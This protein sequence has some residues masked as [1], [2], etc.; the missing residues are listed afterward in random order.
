LLFTLAEV[1]GASAQLTG[2]LD[3]V[4]SNDH[5]TLAALDH[6]Q[7]LPHTWCCAPAISGVQ[8]RSGMRAAIALA[9]RAVNLHPEAAGLHLLLARLLLG[10]FRTTTL[11]AP[12]NATSTAVEH[13]LTARDL[14]RAWDGDSAEAVAVACDACLTAGEYRRAISLGTAAPVGKATA[15]EASDP[16]VLAEVGQAA[17]TVEDIPTLDVVV[18]ALSAGYEQSLLLG[19]LLRLRGAPPTEHIAAYQAAADQAI[20][21][22]DRGQALY[23]LAASGVSVEFPDDLNL[24]EGSEHNTA[25]IEAAACWSRDDFQAAIEI[26][27]PLAPRSALASEL[28]AEAYQSNQEPKAAAAVLTEAARRFGA[29]RMLFKASVLSIQAGYLDGAET[30]AQE[31]VAS[32]GI[33][34]DT[35]INAHLLLLEVAQRR[36]SLEQIVAR[37]R[38]AL[39]RFP[40]DPQFRWIFIR[41][42]TEDR[43]FDHAWAELQRRPPLVADNVDDTRLAMQ[44]SWLYLSGA[45]L[46]RSLL[47]LLSRFPDDVEVQATAIIGISSDS[48]HDVPEDEAA[49]WRSL[50]ERF[51]RENPDHPAFRTISLP[52]GDDREPLFEALREHLEP[53]SELF[54]DL[55]HQVARG[56]VPYGMLSAAAHRP[57]VVA[58]LHRAAG[59]LLVDSAPDEVRR[60]E[61][62]AA[63]AALDGQVVLEASAPAVVVYI[64]ESWRRI[65]GLFE[66]MYTT[67]DAR[68]DA[69]DAKLYFATPSTGMLGWDAELGRPVLTENDPD[70]SRMLKQRADWVADALRHAS[71]REHAITRTKLTDTD[72]AADPRFT[73]WLGPVDLSAAMGLPLYSDDAVLRALARSEGVPA[74]GTAALLRLLEESGR[75]TSDEHRRWRQELRRQY[76]VDL[77]F[78]AAEVAELAA[79]TEWRPGPAAFVL[80]RPATWQADPYAAFRLLRYAQQQVADDAPA[81]AGWLAAAVLGFAAGRSSEEV[82]KVAEPLLFDCLRVID[83]GADEFPTLLLAADSACRQLGE[84]RFIEHVVGEL[85]GRFRA[86]HPA[87]LAA[88][89][90][91][92]MMEGLPVT[93]RSRVLRKLLP[94]A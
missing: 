73:S 93:A 40:D 65:V 22:H 75:I 82:L 5:A 58:L 16:R 21:P 59:C 76:C 50:I 92:R 4:L 46:S 54:R 14:R 19:H 49:R 85:L 28:L 77:P 20:N 47:D 87:D 56:Q 81:A 6:D 13:A 61:L 42:L 35:A 51:L 10:A 53:G 2:V 57:Y 3:A 27:R 9:E 25:M 26:L 78:V 71:V 32:G 86:K 1:L 62:E 33:E 37:A 17:A 30:L 80:S 36:G 52:E 64:P 83:G 84:V 15:T 38:D 29:P 45:A 89:M 90:V 70:V 44:L 24:A 68:N 88:R 94:A 48:H 63:R 11:D 31:A 91:L 23:V 55:T 8:W 60:V 66:R 79:E 18:G 7:V 43:E 72:M 41:A 69:V 12:R 67:A 39:A 74:F 34:R